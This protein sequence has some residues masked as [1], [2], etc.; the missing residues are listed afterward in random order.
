MLGIFG[1]EFG[2]GK[3]FSGI[4]DG[5]SIGAVGE[6]DDVGH[7]RVGLLPLPRER[8]QLAGLGDDW[9]ADPDKF[10]AA[11]AKSTHRGRKIFSRLQ[12]GAIDR[13]VTGFEPA[14]S[15]SQTRRSTKLSY[16][17]E[18]AVCC[19]M[20]SMTNQNAHPESSAYRPS[21]ILA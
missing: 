8:R 11:T 10:I 9:C 18:L 5:G 7:G 12:S 20:F 19:A 13:G 21:R 16:T 2:A 14:T 15:W 3:I 4:G 6:G 17:P 1:R